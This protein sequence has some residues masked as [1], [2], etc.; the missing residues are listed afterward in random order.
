M[1]YHAVWWDLR[2]FSILYTA[3][4]V[5][6]MCLVLLRCTQEGRIP[7]GEGVG[8]IFALDEVFWCLSSPAGVCLNGDIA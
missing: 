7:W 1:G 5:A 2:I 3:G 6:G 8:A 4:C